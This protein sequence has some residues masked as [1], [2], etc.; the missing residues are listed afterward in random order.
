MFKKK[1]LLIFLTIFV[2][3][4]NYS[5]VYLK[6]ENFKYKLNITEII[7][8]NEINKYIVKDLNQQSKINSKNN[9]DIQINTIFTKKILAKN[10][11]GTPTDFELKAKSVFVI[12]YNNNEKT[13]NIEEKL[14]YKKISNNYE[15][16]NYEKTIKKNIAS[17][18][19][20]KLVLRLA[21]LND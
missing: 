5:P 6:N 16:S 7:G 20:R 12:R 11:K 15:Q 4:C 21:I 9:F 10:S 3:N 8:D 18:I 17:S 1:F 14:N 19:A 13:L 2:A